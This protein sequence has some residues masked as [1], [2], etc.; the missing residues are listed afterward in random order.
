[1]AFRVIGIGL[2]QLR[3]ED[4]PLVPDDCLGFEGL[5]QDNK[6]VILTKSLSWLLPLVTYSAELG[7]LGTLCHALINAGSCV[8]GPTSRVECI[9][10][11]KYIK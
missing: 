4:A 6:V 10:K 5:A 11:L 9:H 3:V 2:L 8:V 7:C 1:M